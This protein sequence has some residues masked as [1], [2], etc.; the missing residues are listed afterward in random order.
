MTY[1]LTV[2]AA[3]TAPAAVP[4]YTADA[5]TGMGAVN[6]ASDW[7]LTV[8]TAAKAGTYT[9]TITLSIVSGP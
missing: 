7:W 2:P 4:L 6:L 3:T 5:T 1:P 9:N 8:P